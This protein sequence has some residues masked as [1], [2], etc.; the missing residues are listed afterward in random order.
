MS[1]WKVRLKFCWYDFWVGWYW[2]RKWMKLYICL[3][4]MVVLEVWR[5]LKSM[6]LD[7]ALGVM[8][9]IDEL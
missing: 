1:R 6:H 9:R 8:G 2:D 3:V 4:P 7:R 5:E